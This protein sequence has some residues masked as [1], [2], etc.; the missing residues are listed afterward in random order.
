MPSLLGHQ[1]APAFRT[2]ASLSQ[3]D[4]VKL[5]AR[6]SLFKAIAFLSTAALANIVHPLYP[7]PSPVSC[8][9]SLVNARKGEILF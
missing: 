4:T 1:L 7:L 2:L 6:E 3:F 9:E 5:R 8:A